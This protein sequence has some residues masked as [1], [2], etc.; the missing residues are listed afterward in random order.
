MYK[1]E[2]SSKSATPS[3]NPFSIRID[4]LEP[5]SE[6]SWQ[7]VFLLECWDW[8]RSTAHDLIG[9]HYTT[10]GNLRDIN[11]LTQE[12]ATTANS[13]GGSSSHDASASVACAHE[14]LSRDTQEEDEIA[15]HD[16]TLVRP[17]KLEAGRLCIMKY[18]GEL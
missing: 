14:A 4:H 2:V 6:P 8:N 18:E 3:W 17:D 16:F 13:P 7:E 5:S 10:L 12:D 9:Y 1:S 15:V 11:G